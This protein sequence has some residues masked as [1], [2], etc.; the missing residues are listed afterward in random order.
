V[1]SKPSRALL[2]LAALISLAAAWVYGHLAY[3][4]SVERYL[5]G[6][7]PHATRF[8]LICLDPS[9]KLCL[10]EARDDQGLLAGY[11]TVGEGRGYGGP[12]V[13]VVG[14]SKEGSLLTLR[15]PKHREDAPWFRTLENKGFFEQYIGKKDTDPLELS[16]DVDAV[17]GATFSSYGIGEGVVNARELVAKQL[18]HTVPPRSAPPIKFDVAEVL[19]LLGFAWVVIARALG[20]FAG[21]KWRR[22]PSLVF[23]F[24]VLGIWLGQ[25]L[26]LVN[27]TTWLIGY[28]LPWQ[29]NLFLYGLVFGTLLLAVGLGKNFYCFWLCPF[30]AVQEGAHWLTGSNIRPSEACGKRLGNVRYVLLWLALFLA[31]LSGT[32]ALTIYEPW[33]ALF[34]LKGTGSQWV[35]VAVTLVGA[36]LV[37]NFWCTYL[38]PVGALMEIV[39][40]VRHR[41]AALW[42]KRK[43]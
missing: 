3:D 19:L 32:P 5:P 17:S 10:F 13:V 11:V 1:K 14:W 2:I 38:C 8:H 35:L 15:V 40:K 41:V 20:L 25:P 18:G 26:S 30:S 36:M 29:N 43:E 31:F 42:R 34:T 12:M 27:F 21:M 16:R 7:L 39:L 33:T 24:L 9:E 4:A 28:S 22:V 37:H 6:A 23:G